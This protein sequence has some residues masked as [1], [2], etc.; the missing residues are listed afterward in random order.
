MPHHHSG[1]IQGWLG[2]CST[3]SSVRRPELLLGGGHQPTSR[4]EKLP[5][6]RNVAWSIYGD[7]EHRCLPPRPANLVLKP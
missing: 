2:H 5:N 6:S 7:P 4:M 3:T 1:A